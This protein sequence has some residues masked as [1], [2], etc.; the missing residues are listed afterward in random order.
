MGGHEAEADEG[1]LGGDGGR[2]DGVDEDAL[3]EQIVGD[4]EGLEI[5]ADEQRDDRRGGVADFGTHVAEAFESVVGD[6]PEV[7]LAPGLLN[8]D[9]DGLEGGGGAGGG[10]GGGEDVRTG[11]MAQEVGDF[12]IGGDTSFA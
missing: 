3:L 1:V 12:L 4:T 2:D 7:L 5:V 9:V 11:V 6:V 10:D 8:H